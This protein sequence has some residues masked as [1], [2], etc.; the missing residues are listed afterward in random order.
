MEDGKEALKVLICYI[1]CLLGLYVVAAV[2]TA[3]LRY[4][5]YLDFVIG[6]GLI[7]AF[8]ITGEGVQIFPAIVWFLVGDGIL[9]LGSKIGGG[10]LRFPRYGNPIK[11][12]VMRIIILII[13]PVYTAI[14]L[15][16]ELVKIFFYFLGALPSMLFGK[17]NAKGGKG[18]KKSV[19]APSNQQT[20]AQGKSG[21]AAKVRG[22]VAEICRRYERAYS[23]SFGAG[24]RADCTIKPSVFMNSVEVSVKF[25]F[26]INTNYVNTSYDMQKEEQSIRSF[27]D[28]FSSSA[29]QRDILSAIGGLQKEYGDIY[30]EWRVVCNVSSDVT[31]V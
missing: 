13:L 5:G 31:T 8:V 18:K 15:A 10:Y 19:S 30:G 11:T 4:Y 22:K 16:V 3:A 21:G 9:M 14:K 17:K 2:V 23:K 28:G 1:V 25:F 20:K 7:E 29:L 26:S 6:Q 24:T 27:V 12:I